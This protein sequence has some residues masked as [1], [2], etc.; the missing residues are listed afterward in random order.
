[1]KPDL[2]EAIAR[3][4]KAMAGL[5]IQV[6]GRCGER[7]RCLEAKKRARG[8]R[9]AWQREADEHQ[10]AID[11]LVEAQKAIR[12]I[13]SA[14]AELREAARDAEDVLDRM[15]AATHDGP[16]QGDSGPVARLSLAGRI[17]TLGF[18]PALAEEGAGNG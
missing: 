18:R 13:L 9:A 2:E 14:F 4:E 1:M 16:D 12:A 6:A 15:G 5:A 7:D 11:T 8:G 10:A 17:W 3:V